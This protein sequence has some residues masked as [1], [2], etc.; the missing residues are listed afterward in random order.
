MIEKIGKFD[1]KDVIVISAMSVFALTGITILGYQLH[2]TNVRKKELLAANNTN[3]ANPSEEHF[4]CAACTKK[5]T[6][7]CATDGNCSLK[8]ESDKIPDSISYSN[9]SKM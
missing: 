1:K 7:F 2:K 5:N 3:E 9:L 6:S 4:C 8:N